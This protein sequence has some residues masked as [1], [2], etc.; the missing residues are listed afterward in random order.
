MK[1]RSWSTRRWYT[2]ERRGTLG[3][4]YLP[5]SEQDR[6]FGTDRRSILA[7]SSGD[8]SASYPLRRSDRSDHPAVTLHLFL[9]A[10][11]QE[12]QP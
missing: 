7:R 12:E 10:N 2:S 9:Q 8:A 1:R 11:E 5:G 6:V 4:G 3:G